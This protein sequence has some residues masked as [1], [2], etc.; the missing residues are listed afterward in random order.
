MELPKKNVP[1]ILHGPIEPC[2]ELPRKN[3][4]IVLRGPMKLLRNKKPTV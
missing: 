4:T 3:V 1:R 2:I